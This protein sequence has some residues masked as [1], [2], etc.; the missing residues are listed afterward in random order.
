MEKEYLKAIGALE[1]QASPKAQTAEQEIEQLT[2]RKTA[3]WGK[4]SGRR[5]GELNISLEKQKLS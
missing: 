5:W 1:H 4:W 2:F 3:G